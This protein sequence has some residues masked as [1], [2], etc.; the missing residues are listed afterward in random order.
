[1]A[2]ETIEGALRELVAKRTESERLAGDPQALAM[3][4]LE[5]GLEDD[6]ARLGLV[7]DEL[8]LERVEMEG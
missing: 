2:A 7:L 5:T 4:L 6:L 1:M 8:R 3:A